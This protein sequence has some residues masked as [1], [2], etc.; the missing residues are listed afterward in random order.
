MKFVPGDL[1]R[2]KSATNVIYIFIRAD[3]M[4]DDPRLWFFSVQETGAHF[5]Y[6]RVATAKYYLFPFEEET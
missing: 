2:A 3:T 4:D 6:P 1:Y 5:W